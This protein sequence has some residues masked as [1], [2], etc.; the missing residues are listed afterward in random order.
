MVNDAE[1]AYGY[2][3]LVNHSMIEAMD[4]PMYFSVQFNIQDLIYQEAHRMYQD[5]LKK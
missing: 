1:G 5:S 3:L 4:D 2:I